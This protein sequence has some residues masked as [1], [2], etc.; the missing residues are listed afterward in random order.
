M[1]ALMM[2]FRENGRE[3]KGWRGAPFYWPVLLVQ[4][5]VRPAVYGISAE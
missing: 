3:E 4:K 1:E 5:D 2:F